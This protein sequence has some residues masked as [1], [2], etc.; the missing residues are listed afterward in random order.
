MIFKPCISVIFPVCNLPPNF[1]GQ[2]SVLTKHMK[3]YWE[4]RKSYVFWS[5]QY[6]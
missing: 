5:S 6:I 3:M 2:P 4:Q 1:E